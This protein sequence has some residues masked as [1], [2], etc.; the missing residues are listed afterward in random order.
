MLA[1]FLVDKPQLALRAVEEAGLKGRARAWTSNNW[2]YVEYAGPE[3]KQYTA[4]G[5]PLAIALLLAA[6]AALGVTVYAWQSGVRLEE[7]GTYLL[8]LGAMG[9]AGVAIYSLGQK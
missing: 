5:F 2:L 8:V 3:A 4:Q 6:L 9:L 1:R 7:V